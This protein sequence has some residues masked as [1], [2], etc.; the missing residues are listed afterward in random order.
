MKHNYW[1]QLTQNHRTK[2]FYPAFSHVIFKHTGKGI[3]SPQK[4]RNQL[5]QDESQN[6][7]YNVFLLEA[8]YYKLKDHHCSKKL[9]KIQILIA[10]INRNLKI[11][12]AIKKKN[13]HQLYGSLVPFSEGFDSIL[14][15]LLVNILHEYQ[16]EEIILKDISLI[17]PD[18]L[19]LE[20][21]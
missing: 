5:S 7:L 8:A 3:L 17:M 13:C 6:K 11:D 21:D 1:S 14:I 2:I 4:V 12:S 15:Q 10:N 20:L 18:L 19:S 9:E 16:K